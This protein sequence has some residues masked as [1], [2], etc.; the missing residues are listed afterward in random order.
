MK[1]LLSIM[2]FLCLFFALHTNTTMAEEKK[3]TVR[4]HAVIEDKK[5]VTPDIFMVK[6]EVYLKANKESSI[7]NALGEVDKAIRDL[8]LEYKG[9]QYSVSENCWWYQDKKICDGFNGN[10][11]YV[12]ELKDFAQQNLIFNKLDNISK[13]YKD[14]HFNIYEPVWN[15]S[16]KMKEKVEDGLK[17]TII[18]KAQNFAK[19]IS[20][21][22]G[23]T[24]SIE[25]INYTVNR[26]EPLYFGD[27]AILKSNFTTES[28]IKAPKPKK[29]DTT[30]SVNA[31]VDFNCN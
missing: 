8:G 14:L 9:G 27:I 21:K 4:V 15:I 30:I 2:S 12:F 23:K 18:D 16:D 20:K 22:L 28:S 6:I 7:I 1:K 26:Y 29:E 10:I 24:C 5:Y 19:E 31:S 17:L 11:T 13:K 3:D 25:S